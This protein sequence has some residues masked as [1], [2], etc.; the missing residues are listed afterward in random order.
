[1]S[2]LTRR[3]GISH[4]EELPQQLYEKFF[5]LPC[6]YICATVILSRFIQHFL[7]TFLRTIRQTPFG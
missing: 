2:H 5:L 1:M 6:L 4:Q 7:N 3:G